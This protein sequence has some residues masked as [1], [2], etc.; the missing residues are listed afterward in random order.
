M[1]SK[2]FDDDRSQLDNGLRLYVQSC[3]LNVLSYSDMEYACETIA[4]WQRPSHH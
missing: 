2:K 1:I 3:A 4:P